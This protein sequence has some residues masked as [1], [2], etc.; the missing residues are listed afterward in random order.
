MTGKRKNR[1]LELLAEICGKHI[2]V[3]CISDFIYI[4]F[5]FHKE[6]YNMQRSIMDNHGH[7]DAHF[8][9]QQSQLF[10]YTSI[11]DTNTNKSNGKSSANT[12]K[13]NGKSPMS[14][15]M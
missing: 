15:D 14:K 8:L 1:K 2:V 13:S 7:L 11:A 12:N 5:Q 3:I 10:R 4:L 9:L 6:R